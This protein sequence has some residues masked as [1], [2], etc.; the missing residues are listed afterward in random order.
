MII[1]NN[2]KYFSAQINIEI[3]IFVMLQDGQT[4][5][6]EGLYM[7]NLEYNILYEKKC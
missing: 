4:Y 1:Y 5:L 6:E 7:F 2:L 3:N